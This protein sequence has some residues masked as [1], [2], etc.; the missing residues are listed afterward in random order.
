MTQEHES[1]LVIQ[2]LDRLNAEVKSS[3]TELKE[4]IKDSLAKLKGQ[5]SA[6]QLETLESS[7]M[8]WQTFKLACRI[9]QGPKV[10]QVAL[11]GIQ[12]LI[13]YQYL[14][15][16]EP[17][18]NKPVLPEVS[19]VAPNEELLANLRRLDVAFAKSDEQR[20]AWKQVDEIVSVICGACSVMNG[21]KSQ[22]GSSQAP[23]THVSSLPEDS[24]QLQVLKCLLTVV[25]SLHAQLHGTSLLKC[26]FVCFFI[27]TDST[28][29]IN[30]VTAKASLTQMVN[31][32]FGYFEKQTNVDSAKSDGSQEQRKWALADT[33]SVFQFLCGE[34]LFSEGSSTTEVPKLDNAEG[35]DA[36]TAVSSAHMDHE[37]SHV[38][39]RTRSLALELVFSVM[40]NVGPALLQN[41]A[42]RAVA[43]SQLPFVI[44]RNAITTTPHLFELSVAV[45]M[46]T[47]QFYRQN[48]KSEIEALLSTLFLH[49]LETPN[50]PLSVKLILLQGFQKLAANPAILADLY[51][52]YDCDLT[53]ASVFERI[54]AVI[55]K[56]AQTKKKDPTAHSVSSL[57][58]FGLSSSREQE[59]MAAKQERQLKTEC[60]RCLV[61]ISWSL[62][63]WSKSLVPDLSLVDVMPSSIANGNQLL[64]LVSTSPPSPSGKGKTRRIR[65][66][67]LKSEVSSP[68]SPRATQATSFDGVPIVVTN[69]NPL[70][71]V[72]MPR[73]ASMV[74]VASD[75]ESLHGQKSPSFEELTLR[76]QLF[77]QIVKLFKTKPEK[78]V[79]MFIEEG[80]ITMTVAASD[81][82]TAG[83]AE[84]SK[85]LSSNRTVEN[86]KLAVVLKD[87]ASLESNDS[88]NSSVEELDSNKSQSL[89]CESG[90]QHDGVAPVD[91]APDSKVASTESRGESNAAEVDTVVPG[92]DAQQDENASKKSLEESVAE[93]L[94][95]TRDLNKKAIGEF[96]GSGD[97]FCIRVMYSFV[98]SLNFSG[99]FIV[100]A[101]RQFLQLFR[102]PGE[103][104]KIDRIM[105]KFAD[106]YCE[107]NPTVFAKADTAYTLAFSIIMLNTDLHSSQIKN[108]MTKADFLKNNR[109]INDNNDLPDAFLTQI[110][111]EIGAR[112]IVMEEERSAGYFQHSLGLHESARNSTSQDA[113]RAEMSH[114]QK[115]SQHYLLAKSAERAA[116]MT[117]FQSAISPALAKPM[118]S[119]LAWPLMATL[120][121][122]FEE[123]D[124]YNS[125]AFSFTEACLQTLASCVR[126]AC[127]FNLETE[128]DAFFTSL[129]KLTGLLNTGSNALATLDSKWAAS[130]RFK[131]KNVLAV[132]TLIALANALGDYPQTSWN[133]I[134]KVFSCVDRLS[135]VPTTQVRPAGL[136]AA[137]SN[138]LDISN[139]EATLKSPG[140]VS[141][142]PTTL[143]EP[144][145]TL[146]DGTL[147][148]DLPS[149]P[150]NV[151]TP[152]AEVGL[153]KDGE[154]DSLNAAP[155]TFASNSQLPVESAVDASATS[156][157][158]LPVES[159]VN[160]ESGI[161]VKPLSQVES[162]S[163]TDLGKE[164]SAP[165]SSQSKTSNFKVENL[166]LANVTSGTALKD[167]A[168]KV[169]DST[170][171]CIAE[172][173]SQDIAVAIDR[174][175]AN[176]VN[177]SGPAIVS[178]FKAM[179]VVSGEE[180]G[181]ESNLMSS[182]L[183]GPVSPIG[184]SQ[185]HQL[186]QAFDSAVNSDRRP[187]M[188]L[189]QK[190]VEIAYYNM[191]RI[192]FEW[193]QIWKILQPYFNLIGCHPH[194]EVSTYAVDSL[195]QLCMKFLEKDELSHFH[196]QSELLR[197][198]EWIARTTES[199]PLKELVLHSV[200]QMVYA[201]SKNLKS[202]WR[203][204]FAVLSKVAANGEYSMHLAKKSFSILQEVHLRYFLVVVQAGAFVDFV[205]CVAEFALSD[206][207]KDDETVM[208]CFM[209]LKQCAEL[210]SHEPSLPVQPTMLTTEFPAE[211]YASIASSV[212]TFE[213]NE[214][215]D[216]SKLVDE[217][218]FFLK[219]FPILSAF[220]RV[221]VES[222]SSL[223]RATAIDTLFDILRV[224][225][226]LFKLK[227]WKTIFRSVIYPI[228]EDL[229][230]E[231][232]GDRPL[233]GGKRPNADSNSASAKSGQG[234]D[235]NIWIHG[236]RLLVD[237]Y[238]ELFDMFRDV[239][240]L[241]VLLLALAKRKEDRLAS[242]GQQC[243]VLFLRANWIKFG[244]LNSWDTIIGL[245]E[246]AFQITTPTEL[247][248]CRHGGSASSSSPP[249]GPA[250]S[251]GG[252]SERAV[253]E[254]DLDDDEVLERS[255]S[256]N[257]ENFDAEVN[258]KSMDFGMVILKCAVHLELLQQIRDLLM[259]SV[260]R[261]EVLENANSSVVVSSTIKLEASNQLSPLSSVGSPMSP[262]KSSASTFSASHERRSSHLPDK[263]STLQE[264]W[265]QVS[266]VP[267]L[268]FVDPQHLHRW[269]LCIYRS[270]AFA[271]E[272]NSDYNLRY[273]IWKSGLTKQM[274]NLI[275]QETIAFSAFIKCLFAIYQVYGDEGYINSSGLVRRGN[276]MPEKGVLV[277]AS[278]TLQSPD[279]GSLSATGA[280]IN[281]DLKEKSGVVSMAE[282]IVDETTGILE[283]FVGYL[284]DQTKFQR[285]IALWSPVVIT[286]YVEL[287]RLDQCWIPVSL[288]TPTESLSPESGPPSIPFQ[289]QVGKFNGLRR[290]IVTYF[291]F[292]IQLMTVERLEVRNILQ[293]FMERV[294]DTFLKIPGPHAH[295]ASDGANAA[296][297]AAQSDSPGVST[298]EPTLQQWFDPVANVYYTDHIK[299]SNWDG[300]VSGSVED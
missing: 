251:N 161:V 98:D 50:A 199:L 201:R 59:A 182:G 6:E 186:T 279:A 246:Q 227:Y 117:P 189:L 181:V 225:G 151:S 90:E 30:Q 153:P 287:L 119:V 66:D 78:A 218:A 131:S 177:F 155:S 219:W 113:Y 222:K 166:R 51:F 230:E 179:C 256:N 116:Q 259:S 23:A 92:K 74:R 25:T 210:L 174:V 159:A 62:V 238:T 128:R 69:R 48:L 196:T 11:D 147:G 247:F 52:N 80:F 7:S 205:N 19:G 265:L 232:P 118:F 152:N 40:T 264:R 167:K 54:V 286:V 72:S 242:T 58:G 142:L 171:V 20:V 15:G 300:A 148:K 83:A 22:V 111:D 129:C 103:A 10:R 248:S 57:L 184:Q 236:I 24:V 110:Y 108:K 240:D 296:L 235:V 231:T 195:R 97:A 120:T 124:L 21:R 263:S 35:F 73:D 255:D 28:N 260:M 46:L 82:K 252:V 42:F 237:L 272:F 114:M 193:G 31:D 192:R 32:C 244:E 150:D 173:Q 126:L 214:P 134:L 33:L 228:F 112:E 197:S 123:S 202:G 234:P 176:T 145:S 187:R 144:S 292:G 277:P 267:A 127:V 280:S 250:D 130:L 76:K 43:C 273:A 290:E 91:I 157:A 245:V 281:G 188:Y 261:E 138:A 39:S 3:S 194:T 278:P 213:V 75:L 269:I 68:S 47:V 164:V 107:C 224:S 216:A 55:C 16:M 67:T 191:N 169:I 284:S 180:I 298:F 204:I 79:H 45:F 172:L 163:A 143:A 165:G 270:F 88:L 221:I 26:F 84:N 249:R 274:P 229:I 132:R 268:M 94:K 93:F 64:P 206:L 104:Q 146:K 254:E 162:S 223:V 65:A 53:M 253:G 190:M 70:Q 200:Q 89:V 105:E 258:V 293:E 102:L 125:D 275:K 295:N 56:L 137:A 266:K 288:S 133:Q 115:R 63:Y 233:R 257:P 217:E 17:L 29:T 38:S 208:K 18:A 209:I 27:Y 185:I 86:S 77:R 135:T 178:F 5:S 211:S 71:S 149:L 170:D 297:L 8:M 140:D 61:D 87:D 299:F 282:R 160:D 291:R 141:T 239:Q 289:P 1:G 95:S 198:F 215:G 106:R 36:V 212:S 158:K 100:E 136:P 85:P 2:F 81:V 41:D 121:V 49:M 262:K 203:S 207:G 294:A 12:K 175:Y 154:D 220:S 241:S 37:L 285:D 101:L 109:G 9:D 14:T 96:L 183:S 283:K 122:V 226:R 276:Y 34:A 271:H 60:M 99:T 44:S 156:S 139:S 243:L 168:E 13:A 4:S